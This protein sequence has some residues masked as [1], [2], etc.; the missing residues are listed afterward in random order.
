[1]RGRFIVF[2]GGEGAGK[3]TQA[4]R[5]GDHLDA[6]VTR[7]PGGTS[8]GS[9]LRGL[10]LDPGSDVSDRAEA[11]MMAADRAQHVAEVIG[12]ALESGRHVVCDRY[13]YSSVAYQ[14]FGRQM[15]PDEIRHISEWA[16]DG[17]LPDL[18][19][20]VEVDAEVAA[21]RLNRSLDRFER[22]DAD[23]HERVRHGFH[24]QAVAEP[25]RW[26]TIDGTPEPDVVFDAVLAAVDRR[27]PT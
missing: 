6:L 24:L 26:V 7:E 11:L 27:W 3:S 12:P 21:Q 23:F 19:L 2:E 4:E 14:G 20:L 13:L 22:A 16:T 18:V 17:L 9:T 15:D 8:L 5:L 10:L 25:Y 1:M